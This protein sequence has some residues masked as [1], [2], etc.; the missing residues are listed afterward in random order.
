MFKRLN[1][2]MDAIVSVAESSATVVVESAKTAE[3]AIFIAGDTQYNAYMS[4]VGSQEKALQVAKDR[5][6]YRALRK[7]A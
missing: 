5:N 3:D 7:G 4:L 6:A 2:V 1:K